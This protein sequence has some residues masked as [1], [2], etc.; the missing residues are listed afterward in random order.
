MPRLRI[1]L[2][3]A[4][5]IPLFA[6]S[7]QPGRV[8][9]DAGSG[10]V[11]HV[12]ILVQDIG[13]SRREYHDL[14]GFDLA[15]AEPV[16]LPEGSSHDAMFLANRSYLE[17]LGVARREELLKARAW[18]VGFLDHQ[19]GA[20]SV[21]LAVSSA[22]GLAERLRS[23]GVDAPVSTLASKDPARPFVH[24]TPKLP[25]LPE[26]AIFFTQYPPRKAPAPE[27]HHANSAERIL[28]V[29]I[30]VKN[31]HKASQ[32]ARLLGFRPVRSIRSKVLGAT[33]EEFATESGSILLLQAKGSGL[34][35]AFAQQRSMGVMGVTLA[36]KDLTTARTFVEK[37]TNRNFSTY[38][39]LYGSSFLIPAD[40]A[41]GVWIEMTQEPIGH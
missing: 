39:G 37:Q 8:V 32:D 9:D 27:E 3:L 6:Q 22:E 12:R 13:K 4:L 36:V 41:S 38:R 31:V 19:Q 11:D 40:L 5:G 21:G 33:G 30:V 28:T 18:I 16:V 29:W 35:S 20:H 15:G 25:N 14:L 7:S 24:V 34:V 2:I 17:L 1:F 26:G 10:A 23:R